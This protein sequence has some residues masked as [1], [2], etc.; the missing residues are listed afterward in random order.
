MRVQGP[1]IGVVCVCNDSRKQTRTVCVC[2]CV[3]L[4]VHEG[5][6]PLSL[7]KKYPSANISKAGLLDAL[8]P[9]FTN[10]SDTYMRLLID[11]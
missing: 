9:L 4:C 7:I 5:N 6:V 11:E 8:D 3:W 2:V 1:G 10:L